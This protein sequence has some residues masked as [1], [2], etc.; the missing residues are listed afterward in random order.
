[1]QLLT[2]FYEL[3]LSTFPGAQIPD[4]V[5][6]FFLC[7]KVALSEIRFRILAQITVQIY[8]IRNSR[9]NSYIALENV[10]KIKMKD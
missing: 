7:T 3:F 1:M 4:L 10:G 8:L 5:P 6:E 9:A 2:L